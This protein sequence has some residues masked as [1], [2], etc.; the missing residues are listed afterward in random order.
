MW[1]EYDK[2]MKL[3]FC[4]KCATSIIEALKRDNTIPMLYNGNSCNIFSID[5]ED[6][7][8]DY[9]YLVTNLMAKDDC[10]SSLWKFTNDSRR[11]IIR[12]IKKFNNAINPR[13]K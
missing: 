11:Q 7:H 3:S 4:T 13:E 1:S 8:C 5:D 10:D 9:F 2:G 12:E 6:D